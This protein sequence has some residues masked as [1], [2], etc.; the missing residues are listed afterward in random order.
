[1]KKPTFHLQFINLQCAVDKFVMIT[2]GWFS[3]WLVIWLDPLLASFLLTENMCR[4]KM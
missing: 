2:F 1:M 4:D 3:T